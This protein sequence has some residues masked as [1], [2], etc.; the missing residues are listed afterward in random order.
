MRVVVAGATGLI[1]SKTAAR[2][3]DHGV[4]VALISRREGVDVVTGEGLP[5][6]LRG[7]DVVVD[8]TDAPSRAETA[9]VDFFG[10]ATGNLLEAAGSAGAEHYVILSVV[11]A[12]RLKAG[13]F[14]AKAE[15]EELARRSPIP[16]SIVRARRFFESV[17]DVSRSVPYT[18][19][20]HVVP[21]LTR[22]VAADDVAVA[23]AHVAVGVTL[24]GILEVAGPDEGRLDELT[25]KLLAA[26]GE[27]RAVIA[28][29]P[30]LLHPAGHRRL[31]AFHRPAGQHLA[32]PAMPLEQWRHPARCSFCGTDGRQ[33]S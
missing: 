16:H 5:K 13:Y 23:V 28:A 9:S 4:E 19:S 1:G 18:D 11:G 24:F 30:G 29:R 8:V 31:V 6:V 14:R 20:V 22:P 10:T 7:A 25:E 2:L 12:D 27:K 32:A 15:Q 21:V 3:R 26:Q 33:G 17:E